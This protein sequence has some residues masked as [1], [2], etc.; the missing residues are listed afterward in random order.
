MDPIK[1][2]FE[3]ASSAAN[4]AHARPTPAGGGP[5]GRAAA[6]AA[7]PHDAAAPRVANAHRRTRLVPRNDAA[8]IANRVLTGDADDP[9]TRA[10]KRLR[11]HVLQHMRSRDQRTLSLTTP[12]SGGGTTYTTVNLAISLARELEHHV[13]LVDLNWQRP[14]IA[15]RFGA[16]VEHDL[17]DV[18]EGRASLP[19]ALFNPGVPRLVV[20]PG[21]NAGTR[22]SELLASGAVTALVDELR[23]RYP[24]RFVLFDLPPLL[25]Y[26]DAMAFLPNTDAL[27]LVTRESFT[28]RADTRAALALLEH[29]PLMGVVLNDCLDQPG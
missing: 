14:A 19:D 7:L 27:L 13:C 10:I 6:E 11:T 26:D 4:K 12:R 8:L 21:G 25:G 24:D 29:R 17:I 9:S 22:A 2:A 20:L 23:R 15:T 18:L 28:S 16:H 1:Q 5:A 3:R